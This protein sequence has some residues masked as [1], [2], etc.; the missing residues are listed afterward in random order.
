MIRLL[1]VSMKNQLGSNVTDLPD[2]L[3]FGYSHMIEMREI[4]KTMRARTDLTGADL[5]FACVDQYEKRHAG[6]PTYKERQQQWLSK[7]TTMPTNFSLMKEALEQI[8]DGHNDP[9]AL[10]TEVLNAILTGDYNG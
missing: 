10:A 6:D 5:Y 8:R 2:H 3:K 1:S 4:E 9:R 7:H